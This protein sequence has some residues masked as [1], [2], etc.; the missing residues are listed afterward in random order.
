MFTKNNKKNHESNTTKGDRIFNSIC[1]GI[2]AF[3]ALFWIF[4]ANVRVNGSSMEPTMYDGERYVM[5]KSND[6]SYGDKIIIDG[7]VL[8]ELDDERNYNDM[9]KRVIGL[10]GD[11]VEIYDGL[12]ELN[13]EVL[14][15]EYI[16]ESGMIGTLDLTIELDENEYFVL[17]DNRNFSFDSRHYGAIPEES[18]LGRIVGPLNPMN[19]F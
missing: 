10:P 17:G 15:E 13:G 4:F 2:I 3:S 19:W 9:V 7:D 11:T 18:I 1:L 12:V 5:R 14:E 16:S 8:S 6:V